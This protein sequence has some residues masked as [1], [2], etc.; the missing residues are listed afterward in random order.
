MSR[1]FDELAQAYE[2]RNIGSGEV[3]LASVP[4]ATV[5]ALDQIDPSAESLPPRV[6]LSASEA[7]VSP[8]RPPHVIDPL[9]NY[10]AISEGELY[11][12]V[13]VCEGI[14]LAWDLVIEV[15]AEEPVLCH[16]SR[17]LL[18]LAEQKLEEVGKR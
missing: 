11:R 4:S 5:G 7:G 6:D 8:T 12:R 16:V 18:A 1:S 14:R 17:A 2:D 3:P 13:G 9:E 10:L 15:L